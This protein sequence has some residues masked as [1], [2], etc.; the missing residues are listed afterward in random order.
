MS[1][2]ILY[3]AI[4]AIWVCVLVPRWVRRPHSVASNSPDAVL[5]GDPAGADDELADA[6]A[7]IG[8]DA[9]AAEMSAAVAGASRWLIAGLRMP[10]RRSPDGLQAPES[11][12]AQPMTSARPPLS[13]SR[14]LQ[15][16]RRLLTMLLA[17][18]AVAAACTA[19]GVAQWWICVPP[20]G[21]LGMYV[22]LLHDV[23]LADA[24]NN[25]R[26]QEQEAIQTQAA[27]QR[28]RA[29]WAARVPEP[30]AEII[31]IS[32]RVSDQLYDQYADAT[33][34]AVGD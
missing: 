34:R 2:T 3:L 18:A 32:G 29:A 21:M 22:L 14:I 23:A 19:A 25:R 9:A 33:V 17:L 15:A 4:V 10:A 1:G 20:A 8:T 16:R 31:D 6:Q 11:A 7:D 27:R 26:R 28:A 12:E 13:R 24:E 30:T 5:I